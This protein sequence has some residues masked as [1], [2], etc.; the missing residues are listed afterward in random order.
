VAEERDF[1]DILEISRDASER[2]VKRAYHRLARERHPDKG[3]TPDEVRRLQEEFALIS[4]A[5]NVLKDKQK[6]VEYDAR[7]K[8][9][10]EKRAKEAGSGRPAAPPAK[11]TSAGAAIAAAVKTAGTV[12]QR[13][14][15]AQRAYTKG[16]QLFN[17][18]EYERACEFFEAAIKNDD[19]EAVYHVKLGMALMR[20]RKK[21]SRA[22]TAIKRAIELDPYNIEH[23]L[24]L[25]ESYEMVG[26]DSMAIKTYQEILKWDATNARAL[27]RLTNLGAAP[28]QSFLQ[29]MFTRFTR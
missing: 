14:G 10:D 11:P 17:A 21:F 22:V 24:V 12:Q 29:K 27:E 20:S 1:Y 19:N 4:T 16:V 2:D 8:K 9:E 7:L 15:I 25:G 26:S 18:G 23:R 6:R 3:T 28:G 13:S 5:Y